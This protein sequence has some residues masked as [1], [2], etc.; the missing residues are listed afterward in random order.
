M[1]WPVPVN[2]P[3]IGECI[4]CG[5]TEEPL[6][7]EHA[8][9]Y[10]LNGEWTLLRASCDEC[11]KVTS[12]FEREALR[13]LL[14]AIR[15]VL[16]MRSRRKKERSKTLP[17]VLEKGGIQRTIQVPPGEFPLYLP[18]PI[19]PPPGLTVH[20]PS[21]PG[22]QSHLKLIHVAGPSFAE[23]SKR[24]PGE[25]FVGTRVTYA[26][27]EFARMIAKVAYCI[28]V[29]SL[30]IAPLRESPL[31]DVILGKNKFIGDWVGGWV[32]E[33]MNPEQGLHSARLTATT[34]GDDLHVALRLFAQFGAPEYHVALGRVSSEFVNS[35]EWKFR[36]SEQPQ[37]MPNE[38]FDVGVLTEGRGL[39]PLSAAL[40]AELNRIGVNVVIDHRD[41]PS[42]MAGIEWLLPTAVVVWFTNK[43]LGTLLQEAAKDHYPLIRDAI[44]RLVRRTTGP[45]RELKLTVISSGAGKVKDTDPAALSIWLKREDGSGAVVFRFD[46]TLSGEA[47]S[48][49]V[50]GFLA[51]ALAHADNSV[52]SCEPR[53][54]PDSRWASTVMRFNVETGRWESWI[55]GKDGE[56]KPSSSS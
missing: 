36:P 32:N 22:I 40:S 27:E 39:E 42:V 19:F 12:R 8:V 9:P 21:T 5:D 1:L 53:F 15:N 50:D 3:D 28:G 18:T 23:L 35:P 49:A 56:A 43:Y 25:E 30:G 44:L 31:R 48:A 29:Y 20:R 24:Y 4:Y 37:A 6:G 47:L 26:P 38:S 33:P 17:V 46:Q 45:D 54:L 10:G 34:N 2:A 13:G 52:L 16:G 14:P 11:A 7:T 41:E 51:L 55:L